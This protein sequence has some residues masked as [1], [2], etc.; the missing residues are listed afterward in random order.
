[1]RSTSVCICMYVWE[2]Q[3]TARKISL[4]SMYFN[5]L[6]LPVLFWLPFHPITRKPAPG[7]SQAV[8]MRAC[9]EACHSR[10]FTPE[11]KPLKITAFHSPIECRSRN[12][13]LARLCDL[14]VWTALCS[15]F[16]HHSNVTDACISVI[17]LNSH[18]FIVHILFCIYVK[19]SPNNLR[20][21]LK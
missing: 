8:E 2:E 1:M 6:S 14:S 5:P 20:F 11:H 19:T 17:L 18:T 12:Y 3:S 7:L 21:M 15:N 9:G 16:K 4:S 10:L 13:T